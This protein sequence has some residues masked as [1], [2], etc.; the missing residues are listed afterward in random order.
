MYVYD[1]AAMQRHTC[2]EPYPPA[3]ARSFVQMAEAMALRGSALIVSP[4]QKA[5]IKLGLEQPADGSSLRA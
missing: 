1:D 2:P 5:R 3:V 4:R